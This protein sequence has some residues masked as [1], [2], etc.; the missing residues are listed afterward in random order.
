MSASG[1]G[2]EAR[3]YRAGKRHVRQAAP[4]E[5]HGAVDGVVLR[6]RAVGVQPVPGAVDA[7]PDQADRDHPG[8]VRVQPGVGADQVEYRVD[9]RFGGHPHLHSDLR[10]GDVVVLEDQPVAL[11]VV[12]DEVEERLH[13]GPQPL[14][15]VGGGAQRLAHTGHQILDVALQHR[16]IQLQLAGK[17]LVENRFADPGAL[18]DLVHAGGVVAAVDE[19]VAGR[20][21]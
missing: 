5:Q 7:E 2:S 13:R 8:A 18:G 15:V 1:S 19:D 20:D 21:E 12:L 4:G 9:T 3:G 10:F 6:D 11:A 16:Q 17:M 14:P